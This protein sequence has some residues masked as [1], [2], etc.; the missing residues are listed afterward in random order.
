VIDDEGRKTLP[1][2]ATNAA[3]VGEHGA[4]H[5]RRVAEDGAESLGVGLTRRQKLGVGL[6]VLGVELELE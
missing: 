1:R 3:A 6:E 2:F 5:G 4:L